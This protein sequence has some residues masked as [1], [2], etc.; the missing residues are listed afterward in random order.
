MSRALDRALQ[1][2]WDRDQLDEELAAERERIARFL[3]DWLQLGPGA[4]RTYGRNPSQTYG[5]LMRRIRSGDY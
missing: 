2:Y 4:D 5:D 3:E 1:Q